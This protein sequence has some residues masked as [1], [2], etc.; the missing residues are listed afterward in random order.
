MKNQYGYDTPEAKEGRARM[1]EQKRNREIQ[2][3]Y[4]AETDPLRFYNEPE[5]VRRR[6]DPE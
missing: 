2:E 4:Q 1:D 3:V 6:E 5:S